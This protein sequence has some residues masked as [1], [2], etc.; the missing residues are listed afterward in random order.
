MLIVSQWKKDKIMEKM[1]MYA[2]KL[3]K[4]VAIQSCQAVDAKFILKV[5]DEHKLWNQYHNPY[6]TIDYPK[7]ERWMIFVEVC[8]VYA[9]WLEFAIDVDVFVS[10]QNKCSF[11]AFIL[12]KYN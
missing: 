8:L 10:K 6:L 7:K 3:I 1:F 11:V 12:W 9:L 2:V 5:F 4:R